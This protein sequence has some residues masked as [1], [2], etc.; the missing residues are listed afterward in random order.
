M[1][2]QIFYEKISAPF[3]QNPAWIKGL[4]WL[5]SLLTRVVYVAYPVF[6][7]TLIWNQD[8]RWIKSAGIP[9][10]FFLMLSAVRKWINRKRPYETWSIS[11]LIY[12]DTQGNSM[13]SRHVFSSSIIAM[14]FLAV[15]RPLGVFFLLWSGMLALVRVVGGV[16]YPSDV[17]VGFA[18]GVL[19]GMLMLC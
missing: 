10:C 17:L 7:L 1:D 6:L 18:A 11:P 8:E 4:N 12:K 19:A 16:H 15:S 2:Y 5:N 13:P 3:R 14:A 9:A